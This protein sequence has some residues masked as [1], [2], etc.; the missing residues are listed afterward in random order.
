[1]TFKYLE[2]KFNSI[3]ELAL[4]ADKRAE[5]RGAAKERARLRREIVPLRAQLQ[6]MGLGMLVAMT[7]DITR[8]PKARKR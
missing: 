7:H 5:A 4:A 3:D 2:G 8:A 1:M 6:R